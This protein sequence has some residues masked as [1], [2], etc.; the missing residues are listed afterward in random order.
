MSRH[1]YFG[2]L[3][4]AASIGQASGAE[5]AEL[6][7]HLRECPDCRQ[8]YSDFFKLN[9]HQYATS[10]R[11]Q[12]LGHDE[13]VGLIDSALFRERFLKKAEAEGI[14]ISSGTGA[15]Q[16]PDPDTRSPW[17]KR[18]RPNLLI[19][20]AASIL[21]AC[22]AVTG[23]HLGTRTA[24][25]APV[26]E[27]ARVAPIET[28]GPV[29]AVDHGREEVTAQLQE[30]NRKLTLDI[31]AMKVGLAITSNNA[32]QLEGRM[33]ASEKERWSLVAGQKDH[34]ATIADLQAR[35][36]Q[37]QVTLA[38]I[39]TDLEKAQTDKEAISV[40]DQVNIKQLSEQLAEKSSQL[41]RER[42]L[43]GVGRDIRD[44]MAARNLHIADVF[45]TDPNS[46]TRRVF[47]R[48]FYTEGKSLLFYAYDLNDRRVENAGY[49]Y[50]VWG[51]RE[52][53]GQPSRSLGIFFSDDKS[54]RRWVFKYNDPKVLS[55][56]DSVFVTLE[57]P[58]GNPAKPQ[59]EKLMYAYVRGQANHP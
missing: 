16:I 7:Q 49:Q 24:R 59:G 43:L 15:S 27:G 52:G 34:D 20:V 57:P 10:T 17:T 48:I 13:A 38:G 56:I 40:A 39:R 36:N 35:L 31:E 54:Q 37:A 32:A 9:A 41:E 18:W 55:E 42:E 11:E 53:L 21:F 4:A 1:E 58:N 45:D 3:S 30:E 26:P 14:V 19:P 25:K 2:E 44:L 47:G 12:E 28:P 5:L 23:Y 51:K 6:Q 29:K 46:K 33:A 22:A 8:S 50:R